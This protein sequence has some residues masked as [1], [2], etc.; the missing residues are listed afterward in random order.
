M[1]AKDFDRFAQLHVIASVQPYHAID[2]GRFAESHIDTTA[3]AVP[4]PSELFSI[5]AS[6]SLS[7]PTGR[8]RRSTRPRPLCRRNSRHL[9]RQEPRRLVPDE[10]LTVAE[11][12][13][14][15][16]M[17]SASPN[18]EKEKGSYARGN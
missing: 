4:T 7:A 2:D 14:A 3:P 16:T 5:T 11:A 9:G 12:V 1:A 13:E 10:K 6:A 17:G 18:Q 8:W 15:Y